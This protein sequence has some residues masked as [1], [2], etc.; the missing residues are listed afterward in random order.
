MSVSN[1]DDLQS[2]Q[3]DAVRKKISALYKE[4]KLTECIQECNSAINTGYR[5]A[6]IY[7]TKAVALMQLG[8]YESAKKSIDIAVKLAPDNTHYAKNKARIHAK[9]DEN[10]AN[11]EEEENLVPVQNHHQEA[12]TILLAQ[13]PSSDRSENKP[14]MFIVKSELDPAEEIRRYKFM[15]DNGII[16][17]QYFEM[18]RQQLQNL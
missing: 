9:I 7:N 6:G 12:E 5:N 11:P 8:E 3:I 4:G 10:K 14:H 18:K 17:Q 2:S 16:D 15:L 13:P 1:G